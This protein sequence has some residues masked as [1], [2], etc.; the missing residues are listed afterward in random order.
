M[1]ATTICTRSGSLAL[2]LNGD[3]S[4]PIDGSGRILITD[5]GANNDGALI[6]DSDQ[7]T[8]SFTAD[9]YI[10]AANQST[11]SQDRVLSEDARGWHRNRDTANGIVRLLRNDN[12]MNHFEGVFTCQIEE[13]PA[14]PISVGIYYPSEFL[15]ALHTSLQ[16]AS[17][18]FH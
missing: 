4:I 14:S 17:L 12:S 8:S 9:W 6:C 10:N 1:I 7:T 3:D 13:D 16:N 18:H 5:I 15:L 11:A 2:T